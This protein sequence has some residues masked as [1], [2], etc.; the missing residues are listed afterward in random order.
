VASPDALEQDQFH[1]DLAAIL[2][3]TGNADRAV[4]E[5]GAALARPGWLTRAW[6]AVDWRVDPIRDAE[7]FRELVAEGSK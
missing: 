7:G 5:L 3:M 2:A 6:L 4:E 1:R